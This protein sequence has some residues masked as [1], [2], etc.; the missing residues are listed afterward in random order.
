MNHIL[1]HIKHRILPFISSNTEQCLEYPFVDKNGYGD[2]HYSINYVRGH[3][4]AH[5]A[6]YQIKNNCILTKDQIVMHICDNP[7]CCNPKHLIIG[8][9]KDNSEDMLSDAD[10][11]LDN[12]RKRIGVW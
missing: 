10:R 3:L 2:I 6:V 7:S 1:D 8:T 12:F 5:R 4:L 11:H 9:H